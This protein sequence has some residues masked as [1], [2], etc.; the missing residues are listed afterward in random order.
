MCHSTHV[1]LIHW[2]SRSLC[3][4]FAEYLTY[5]NLKVLTVVYNNENQWFFVPFPQFGILNRNLK[6]LNHNLCTSI[7]VSLH[8]S[9]MFLFR[10]IS[11][12]CFCFAEYFTHY[13]AVFLNISITFAEY[14][15]HCVILSP[16][17]SLTNPFME[18]LF[19]RLTILR[20][21]TVVICLYFIQYVLAL[22]LGSGL[23]FL[24][25]GLISISE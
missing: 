9:T 23:S 8:I 11:Q 18:L 5:L 15:T 6:I 24:F 10:W 12:L 4:S 25:I 7:T 17:A 2:N 1:F 19:Y 16:A 3:S 22:N 21:R 13:V 20:L 14:F